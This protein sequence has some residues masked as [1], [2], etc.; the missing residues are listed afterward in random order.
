MLV[1]VE[2]DCYLQYHV[3]QALCL[4][5]KECANGVRLAVL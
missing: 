1:E 2:L 3:A 4:R 5:I